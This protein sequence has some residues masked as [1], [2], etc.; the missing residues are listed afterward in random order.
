MA[1][2]KV[3]ESTLRNA[4]KD[5]ERFPI[6]TV[7]LV[8]PGLGSDFGLPDSFIVGQTHWEPCELKRGNSVVKGLR[9][10]QRRWHRQSLHLGVQTY[11]MTLRNDGVVNV[12]AIRLAGGLMG[13]LSEELLREVDLTKLDYDHVIRAFYTIS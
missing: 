4:L 10:T 5:E 11:G 9:P 1:K 3:L 13:G 2:M 6:G 8:E 7:T 12:V